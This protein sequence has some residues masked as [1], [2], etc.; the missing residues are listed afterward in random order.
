MF[1]WDNLKTQEAALESQGVRIMTMG[2][3]KGL[4]CAPLSSSDLK[5]GL[6]RGLTGIWAKSGACS[7]WQ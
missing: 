1:M 5:K 2:G 4:R 7:T 6:C 3:S